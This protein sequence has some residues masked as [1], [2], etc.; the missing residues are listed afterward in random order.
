LLQVFDHR[1]RGVDV[2]PIDVVVLKV[3]TEPEVLLW[4]LLHADA[5]S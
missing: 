2:P 4:F 3:Q 1:Q 5:V